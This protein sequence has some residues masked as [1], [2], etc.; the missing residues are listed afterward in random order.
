[1]GKPIPVRPR[2][3]ALLPPQT[4]PNSLAKTTTHL[5][6]VSLSA[7][8]KEAF[9]LIDSLLWRLDEL[10]RASGRWKSATKRA[11]RVTR[12]H[13]KPIGAAFY[14]AG[15]ASIDAQG[16][17]FSSIE[18][19]LAAWARLSLLFFPTTDKSTR[20]KQ[21]ANRGEVLRKVWLVHPKTSPLSDRNL[22]NA[23]MH[24]REKW[25]E[26]RDLLRPS[27]GNGPSHY[28]VPR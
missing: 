19:F 4:R 26:R 6:Q 7:Y 28:P 9:E 16:R 22:R 11:D 10:E 20:G 1:M 8:S 13:R 3:L 2:A 12:D 27:C 25:R 24:F 5:D 21:R 14:R 23:W 18:A 15:R 17:A